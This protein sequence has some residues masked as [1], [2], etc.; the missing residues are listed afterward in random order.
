MRRLVAAGLL[1]ASLLAGGCTTF[2]ESKPEED[3]WWAADKAQ[4][5]TL[6]AASGFGTTWSVRALGAEPAPAVAGGFT[7]TLSGGLLKELW[8]ATSPTGSGW[9]WKDLA[10]DLAGTTVGTWAGATA[11]TPRN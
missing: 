3:Q 8:D 7:I 5:F 4:H 10:W 11:P 6:S 1:G 9:S 2:R